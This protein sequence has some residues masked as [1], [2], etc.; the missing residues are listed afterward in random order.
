MTKDTGTADELT[1]KK[2]VD[3]PANLPNPPLPSPASGSSLAMSSMSS[4]NW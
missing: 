2:I 1:N 4:P 3:I